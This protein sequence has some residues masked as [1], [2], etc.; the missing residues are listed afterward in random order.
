MTRTTPDGRS[1]RRRGRAR[2]FVIG[3][4]VVMLVSL[5]LIQGFTTKTVGASGEG[6]SKGNGPTPL[7]HMPPVLSFRKSKLV[8]VQNRRS[9]RMIALTFDDGPNPLYTPKIAA[10]LHAEHVPATFF[11][12]GSMVVRYSGITRQLVRDGFEIGNHTFTHANLAA[13]PNWEAS[14]QIAATE[15]AIAGVTGM[16][17]RLVRPPYASTTDAVGPAEAR[18]LTAVASRGYDLVF[19]TVDTEDWTRP[20]VPTIVRNA[21]PSG[22]HGGIV[23]MHDAGGLR[24]Q[25][26]KAL[27]LVIHEL[28]ARGYRFVDLSTYMGV[29][30]STIEL[31]ASHW[32]QVRGSLLVTVLRLV[33]F[34]VIALTLLVEAITVIVGLRMA[35]SLGLAFV[36]R[37]RVCEATFD[38]AFTPAVSII[39]PAYNEAVGIARCVQSLAGSRYAGQ[40]EVVVVDDGSADDTAAV[41]EHLDLADVRLIRQENAGKAAALNR[42]LIASQHEIVVT[43]DADTVFEPETLSHLVQRF[44]DPEVGVISGNTKI[45][46]RGNL[47]GRWQHIEYVMGFNLDRRAYEVIG[48]TP[49]VPGAIGAFRRRALADI[50]GVSGATIAED[51]DITLDLGRAGWKVV[52][53][54]RARAWTEAPSNLRA[55]YR[56]RARWAYGTIQSA[57]KHRTALWGRGEHAFGR[58]AVGVLLVFQIVLP[59]AAPLIDLFAIYSIL[60]LDPMPILVFWGAF[61]LFQLTLAWVAF[62]LDGESRRPLWALPLQQLAWRQITYFVVLDGI[63]SA[64]LG[65]QVG[66]RHLERTGS[67]V[68]AGEAPV[69]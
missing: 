1:L 9:G 12:V 3:T 51:T 26:V 22:R 5:L 18:A 25:T 24:D 62:G 46:N 16:R 23:L 31:P 40:L 63:I 44:R 32:D 35:I 55:L 64:L 65:R 21:L 42:A 34:I 28:R 15:S 14:A 2:H 37:R 36:Q 68:T 30:R 39:V 59:L 8:P 67:V 7:A 20:G 60:F 13:L 57:W 54:P 10:I 17:P 50:G 56:Q 52:Y 48:A 66:W 29:P 61:N 38:P 19:S 53:E 4:F 43:V 69:R 45:G 41:V 27:P 58:R 11:E 47:V 49:T 33:N 6:D